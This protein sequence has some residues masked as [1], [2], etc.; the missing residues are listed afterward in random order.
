M[1]LEHAIIECQMIALN[2]QV[3]IITH[4]S[5]TFEWTESHPTRPL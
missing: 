1:S 3:V 2:A 4:L 5:R